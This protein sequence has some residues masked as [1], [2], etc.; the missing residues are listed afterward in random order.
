ML[1]GSL[2]EDRGVTHLGGDKSLK[3]KT[4]RTQLSNLTRTNQPITTVIQV[5]TTL[6][7]TLILKE[8]QQTATVI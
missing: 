6:I 2:K 7:I 3:T 1:C 4:K 5:R 8:W